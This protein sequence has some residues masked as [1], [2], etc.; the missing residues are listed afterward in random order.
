[1][2]C[3]KAERSQIPVLL[4]VLPPSLRPRERLKNPHKMLKDLLFCNKKITVEA[5]NLFTWY[6]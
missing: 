5:D 6:L 2:C 4:G 3:L 1:L